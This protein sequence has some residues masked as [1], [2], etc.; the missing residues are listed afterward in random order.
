M[1]Y[2]LLLDGKKKKDNKEEE[3]PAPAPK[4]KIA[5]LF[6]SGKNALRLNGLSALNEKAYD[7]LHAS[8]L[9]A[10]DHAAR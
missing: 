7:F 1:V 10:G 5:K 2:F 9:N 6:L 4:L 8:P 3:P